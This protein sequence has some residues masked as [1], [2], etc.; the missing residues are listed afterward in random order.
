M[1]IKL[2]ANLLNRQSDL[3]EN[4]QQSSEYSTGSSGQFNNQGNEKD[5][6]TDDCSLNNNTEVSGPH[7]DV[8]C[9]GI[10]ACR[11][12]NQYF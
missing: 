9:F 3:H 11:G 2:M 4:S 8:E 1:S 10:T 7:E 5:H 6:Q 12:N